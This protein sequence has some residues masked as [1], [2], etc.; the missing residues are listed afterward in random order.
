MKKLPIKMNFEKNKSL[1]F[2]LIS[3]LVKAKPSYGFTLIELLIVITIIVIITGAGSVSFR[4]VQQQGRDTKRQTDV[5]EIQ[6]ALEIYYTE[7]GKYP[8]SSGC[9]TSACESA[10]PDP[11]IPG[12]NTYFGNG[13]IKND[14]INGDTHDDPQAYVY[15]Y[16]SAN[17]DQNYLITAGIERVNTTLPEDFVDSYDIGGGIIYDSSDDCFTFHRAPPDNPTD[18]FWATDPRSDQ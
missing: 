14:P 17:N 13:L 5:A 6:S 15:V 8:P 2:T 7:N 11:W 4:T 3:R 1:G 10:D 18:C 9:V 16:V 12:I